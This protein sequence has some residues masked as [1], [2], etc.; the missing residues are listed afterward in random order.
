M[1]K[2]LEVIQDALWFFAEVTVTAIALAF[3]CFLWLIFGLLV[4]GLVS[5][6]F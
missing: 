2:L 6:V 3:L 5:H 1:D 4:Y